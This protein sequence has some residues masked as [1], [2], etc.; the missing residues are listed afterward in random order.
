MTSYALAS[1]AESAIGAEIKLSVPY[2]PYESAGIE[3]KNLKRPL[4]FLVTLAG[5]AARLDAADLRAAVAF[6]IDTAHGVV[7]LTTLACM[8]GSYCHAMAKSLESKSL[9]NAPITISLEDS[10]GGRT[11]ARIDPP[12]FGTERTTFGTAHILHED[13]ILGLYILEIGPHSA[14]PAHCHWV[15]RES[16]LI[17]DDGL[18]QQGQPV[19][20]GDAYAW[21]LG[22]VHAYRNPTGQPRRILCVDSPRFRPAD[23]V[24]LA[25]GQP[26]VLMPPLINYLA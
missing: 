4:S 21:P 11:T 26:L 1:R 8:I 14:I 13:A 25:D 20:R 15:M 16:E 24:P 17:L 19:A 12:D 3:G 7:P 23:E 6:L 9:A 22:Y 10:L 18:L 2:R 5:S